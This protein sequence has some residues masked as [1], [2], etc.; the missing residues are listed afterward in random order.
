MHNNLKWNWFDDSAD[1]NDARWYSDDVSFIIIFGKK[2]S[3]LDV[4]LFFRFILAAMIVSFDELPYF[5][6]EIRRLPHFMLKLW[7]LSHFMVR[8]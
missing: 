2:N 5:V 1:N 3:N 6:V 8:I 7:R 4:S